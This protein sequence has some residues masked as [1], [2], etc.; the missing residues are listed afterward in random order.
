MCIARYVVRDARRNTQDA[1]AAAAAAAGPNGV[2]H[3]CIRQVTRSTQFRTVN[4]Q[5]DNLGIIRSGD[6]A[7]TSTTLRIVS[8]WYSPNV[9]GE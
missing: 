3:R 7:D 9:T 8:F 6:T 4:G 2:S 5:K 1:I